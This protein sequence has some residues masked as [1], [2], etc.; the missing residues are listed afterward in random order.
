MIFVTPTF[1]KKEPRVQIDP[2][3]KQ[4][5]LSVAQLLILLTPRQVG[6]AFLPL[7][8]CQ[9]VNLDLGDFHET[10]SFPLICAMVM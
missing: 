3:P 8:S 4:R 5:H 9:L 2:A 7:L 1:R 10:A 6:A